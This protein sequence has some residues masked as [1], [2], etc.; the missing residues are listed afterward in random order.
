MKYSVVIPIF[1]E[2]ESIKILFQKLKT[3]FAADWDKTEIIFVN[4]GSTDAT[5]RILAKLQARRANVKVINFRVNK[6]KSE[7]LNAGFSSV[8]G[9]II[10]TLD[11]DLQDEPNEIPKLLVKLNQG[12]DLVSSWKKDRRDPKN[13]LVLTKIFNVVVRILTGINLHDFNSG[14]KA[15]KLEVV[16]NLVLYGELH[17]F[18]PVLAKRQGFKIAEVPV[19]H[20]RRPFGQSKYNWTRVP[21]GFFDLF[22]VLFLSYFKTSPMY[23][24]GT[25]G[26]ALTFLGASILIHL[27]WLRLMGEKIGSRPLLTFGILFVISGLQFFFTGFLAELIVHFYNQ[28]KNQNR[29]KEDKIKDIVL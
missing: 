18:I 24:F 1:N 5:F 11:A 2:E 29:Q 28:T 14:L 21:K 12:F 9:E 15:Y 19:I 6:G 23:F 26:L 25:I 8:E 4:D 22:T 13:R 27:S 3:V 20:H 7:A 17:R 16:K 10:L